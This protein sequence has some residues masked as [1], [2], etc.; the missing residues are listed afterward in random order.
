MTKF[1]IFYVLLGLGGI[2]A[3]S[4]VNQ[5]GWARSKQETRFIPKSVMRSTGGYRSSNFWLV[6]YGG[7]GGY[8]GGK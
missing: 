8:R 5:T 3:F 2:F 6:G 1:A 7:Y 4:Y